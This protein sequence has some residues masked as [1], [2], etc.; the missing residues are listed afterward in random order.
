MHHNIAHCQAA[1]SAPKSR[2]ALDK[3]ITM[4]Q[5]H[6]IAWR[7]GDVPVSLQ[8]DDPFYSLENG[9]A[10]TRYVFLDG[11]DLPARF[12]PGFHIA[13]LGFGTGLNLAAAWHLWRQSGQTGQLH[14]TSFE[15]YPLTGAA[16]RKA[17]AAFGDLAPYAGAIGDALDGTGQ[18]I[19]DNMQFNLILGDARETLPQWQNRADAWFL[20]GFAPTQNPDLWQYDLMQAVGVHTKPRG[21]FATYTAAGD[22]RRAL[23]DAGFAV[24]RRTG[25]GRK[26]HMTQGV[27][28]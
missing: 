26:R 9:L 28:P 22:V 5:T 6:N 14:F 10:E 21:S 8:F 3:R 13:E 24:T 1:L 15:A 23:A 2:I 4:S 25:Y 11:N 12:A 20:D 18:I 17:L 7:D 19:T 27:M 16:A